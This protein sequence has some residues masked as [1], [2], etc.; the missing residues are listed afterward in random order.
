MEDQKKDVRKL[1][2]AQLEEFFLAH[3]EKKFRAKQVY[4]WLWHK[5]LKNF[6]DMSNIS[7]STR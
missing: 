7:L 6:D 5:S 1:S 3:G 2:L 4:E